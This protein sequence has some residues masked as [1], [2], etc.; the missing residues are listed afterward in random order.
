[1]EGLRAP[2]SHSRDI[3]VYQAQPEAA[4]RVGRHPAGSRYLRRRKLLD[5]LRVANSQKLPD[6]LFQDDLGPNIIIDIFRD[7]DRP[8]DLSIP[9]LFDLLKDSV[10]VYRERLIDANPEPL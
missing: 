2:L 10:F 5:D 9:A 4:T 7:P 6:V 3:T 8:S 1:M